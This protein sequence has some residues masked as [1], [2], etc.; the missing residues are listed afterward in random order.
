MKPG[1]TWRKRHSVARQA[2]SGLLM[3]LKPVYVMRLWWRGR[4]EPLYRHAIAERLGD[5][6]GE[7]WSGG[8]WVHAVSLGETRA[9]AALID[10]LR[11][12]RPGL[13]LLLTHST[14]TGRHAGRALMCEGDLQAW[15]PY[16]TPGVVQ[17]FFARFRPAVG[18]L[19]ETEVWPNL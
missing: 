14:A 7:P 16:D 4:A 19:M 6:R 2:Y 13:R 1:T 12:Q 3:L 11:V 18:V 15:L 9:A 17:R 8:L 5:Y 10:A